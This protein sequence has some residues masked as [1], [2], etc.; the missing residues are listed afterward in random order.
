M[1]GGLAPVQ[2]T[3]TRIG[4]QAAG[5]GSRGG[6]A[7]AKVGSGPEKRLIIVFVMTASVWLAT[8]SKRASQMP[9]L[10]GLPELISNP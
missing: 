4:Q 9:D 2:V 5:R 8:L 3:G 1:R 6:L 7:P 10:P